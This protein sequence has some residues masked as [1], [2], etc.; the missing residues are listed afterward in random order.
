MDTKHPSDQTSEIFQ[1]NLHHNAPIGITADQ[2]VEVV[3]FLEQRHGSLTTI[4]D[5]STRLQQPANPEV[6]PIIRNNTLIICARNLGFGDMKK[7]F[8]VAIVSGKDPQQAFVQDI[9]LLGKVSDDQDHVFEFELPQCYGN[10]KF[11]NMTGNPMPGAAWKKLKTSAQPRFQM[12]LLDNGNGKVI[13]IHNTGGDTQGE[14]HFFIIQGQKPAEQQVF[15]RGDRDLKREESFII[16]LKGK[17]ITGQSI[18]LYF[19][20]KLN[21]TLETPISE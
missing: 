16:H 5:I 7:P 3:K 13:Q 20:G 12:E 1:Q 9:Q 19:D 21:F 8:Q 4:G 11:L 14:G 2:I 10:I 17:T 6:W 15:F 18:K